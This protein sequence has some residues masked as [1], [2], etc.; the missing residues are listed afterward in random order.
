[1]ADKPF[2]E[3]E[4]RPDLTIDLQHKV[5]D[6]TVRDLLTILGSSSASGP[7]L[8]ETPT[9]AGDKPVAKEPKDSKDIK[10]H[11]EPKDHKDQKEQ[12]DHKDPKDQKDQKD[13][14]EP[15][16]HKDQKD[17]KD[18]KDPKDPKESKDHKDQKDPKEHKDQKDLKD[19]KEHIKDVKEPKEPVDAKV[20]DTAESATGTMNSDLDALVRR[21]SGLEQAFE[22]AKKKR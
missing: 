1:M 3:Q 19:R 4:Q 10:D 22:E 14:K 20:T 8:K 16:D 17:P 2:V 15:K 9:S 12:K 11:K 21:V 18:T 7:K 13:Q 5:G 6:L